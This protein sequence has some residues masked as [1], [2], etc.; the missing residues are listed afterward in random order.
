MKNIFIY[1]DKNFSQV[2]RDFLKARL[3]KNTELMGV[4]E[5][6]IEDVKINKDEAVIEYTKKFDNI[7]LKRV[8]IFFHQ[9]EIQKGI[10]KISSL[11]RKS[12]STLVSQSFEI[13]SLLIGFPSLS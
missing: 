10:G 11:D 3:Q 12:P 2:F 1:E 4:V 5:K 7:D 13:M 9:N 6:I 8:G